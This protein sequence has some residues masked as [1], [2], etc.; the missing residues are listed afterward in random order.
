MPRKKGEKEA[1]LNLI[2][3]LQAEIKQLREELDRVR[4]EPP[5]PSRPPVAVS[6]LLAIK[7]QREQELEAELQKKIDKT[8]D[9]IL[10]Y[11]KIVG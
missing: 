2:Q 10:K 5:K 11:Y 8:V 4:N 3:E 7:E 6:D 9:L 1:L